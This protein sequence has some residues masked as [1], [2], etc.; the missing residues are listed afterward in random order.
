MQKM[1][2]ED[3][4]AYFTVR[5]SGGFNF[6]FYKQ[7][8]EATRIPQDI[9][10]QV[11]EGTNSKKCTKKLMKHAQEIVN[12][13]AEDL[14]MTLVDSKSS[15]KD[16]LKEL[17]LVK[18]VKHFKID[19]NSKNIN[20]IASNPNIKTNFKFEDI[21]SLADLAITKPEL[22]FKIELTANSR[23][24]DVNPINIEGEKI[25]P[26]KFSGLAAEAIPLSIT[27]KLEVLNR[28]DI[29][30]NPYGLVTSVVDIHN[31]TKEYANN[32]GM[33]VE[34]AVKHLKDDISQVANKNHHAGRRAFLH[35]VDDLVSTAKS[36]K[37]I[38][39]TKTKEMLTNPFKTHSYF[40]KPKEPDYKAFLKMYNEVSSEG[41]INGE[42]NEQ[43]AKEMLDT[44][45][46]VS[47]TVLP[48]VV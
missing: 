24:P 6:G 5:G 10:L 26:G 1:L 18:D 36:E 4:Q 41:F 8:N 14:G 37:A 34:D 23:F 15:A 11:F 38:N 39:I 40:S 7:H 9:D 48:K 35:K 20:N 32:L 28:P 3:N 30:D 46:L 42:I 43:Q 45:Y 17:I 27:G 21:E 31:F 19:L 22:D 12:S 13:V 16:K 29:K 47:N 2:K 44:V 33:P 25:E